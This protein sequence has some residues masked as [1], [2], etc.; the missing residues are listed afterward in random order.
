M[1]T[2]YF[3]FLVKNVFPLYLTPSLKLEVLPTEY[4]KSV[5]AI[6]LEP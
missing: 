5:S 3:F 2:L 4:F 6:P 1:E